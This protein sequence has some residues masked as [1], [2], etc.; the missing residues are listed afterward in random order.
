MKRRQFLKAAAISSLAIQQGNLA[1][2]AGCTA[3]GQIARRPYKDGAELS[4]IG[5]GGIVVIGMEQKD[6]DRTVADSVD[7]GVNYFDVAPSYGKGEAEEKLGPA[8]R[9]H[10]GKAFLACK[11]Q[12]RDAEGARQELEQSLK[13]LH[14]DHFDLYQLHAMSKMEDVEKVLAPGGAMELFEKARE[15]GK[16]RYLGFSA[17]SAEAAVA[18]MDRY[19]FDSILFPINY[20]CYAEGNFGPQ[21]MEKA[22]EK[23]VARLALKA[24]AHARRKKGE[25]RKYKKCWYHAIDELELAQRAL[26]FTLSEEVTAA[27]PPGDEGLYQMA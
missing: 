13:R 11:T 25:E 10:R 26:R 3:G 17:H 20:V 5:F 23:G 21:V 27:V 1:F 12:M 22:E 4:I 8:L 6:A 19:P 7:R 14:T 15:E 9:P 24:L 2:L 16:V 18:L